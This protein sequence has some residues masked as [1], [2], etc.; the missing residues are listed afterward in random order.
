MNEDNDALDLEL[1]HENEEFDD[2]D[3]DDSRVSD[4]EELSKEEIKD[5]DKEEKEEK[6]AY[7]NEDDSGKHKPDSTNTVPQARFNQERIK[8][9]QKDEVIAQLN[10]Q[11]E[12]LR[13]AKEVPPPPPKALQSEELKGLYKQLKDAFFE[14][15]DSAIEIQQKIDQYNREAAEALIEQ[16]LEQRE[17]ARLQKEQAE[18]QKS[19]MQLMN[20]TIAAW[21]AENPALDQDSEDFD[22]ELW[23]D[24]MAYQKAL[25]ESRRIT[26]NE[27]LEKALEKIVGKGPAKETGKAKSNV[28]DIQDERT[29]RSVSRGIE[30]SKKAA[31]NIN[32]AST[33]NRSKAPLDLDFENM[34]EA[35][36][37]KLPQSVIDKAKGRR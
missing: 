29:K 34:S 20:D 8:S 31:P 7:N 12:E 30:A 24:T 2:D 4:F 10:Q 25:V 5:D 16:K 21:A 11:L 6:E 15:D 32:T 17:L 18:L 19:D 1:D 22:L 37:N 26:G 27:A 33:G 35:E 3:M 36:F 9:K 13:Q 14:D 23:N 28:V